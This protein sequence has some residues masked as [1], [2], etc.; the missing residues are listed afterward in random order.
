M[1]KTI[2]VE[3]IIEKIERL[4]NDAIDYYKDMYEHCYNKAL[5]YKDVISDFAVDYSNEKHCYK[6]NRWIR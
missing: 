5:A 1:R 3:K 6:R 4:N 2:E